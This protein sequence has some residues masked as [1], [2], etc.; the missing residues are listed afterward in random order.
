M[1]TH[2]C[3]LTRPFTR[4]DFRI[5]SRHPSSP[6]YSIRYFFIQNCSPVYCNGHH[7]SANSF[8]LLEIHGICQINTSRFTFCNK[9]VASL[10]RT[11][12]RWK[13][14]RQRSRNLSLH[15]G[16]DVYY[17]SIDTHFEQFNS[18]FR[19]LLTY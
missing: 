6:V 15:S 7:L 1:P 11:R 3:S 2:L 5:Y 14:D 18:Q 16:T 12:S 19:F 13:G 4:S 9:N 10:R 8:L 17:T